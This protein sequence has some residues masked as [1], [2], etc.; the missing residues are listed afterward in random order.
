MCRAYEA[1]KQYITTRKPKDELKANSASVPVDFQMDEELVRDVYRQEAN[2]TVQQ[3]NLT[4]QQ[5]SV[6][7]DEV[8]FAPKLETFKWSQPTFEAV[9]SRWYKIATPQWSYA[10]TQD[11]QVIA[12]DVSKSLLNIASL[13]D[14]IKRFCYWRGGVKIR[15]QT[16]STPFHY[17]SLFAAIIPNYNLTESTSPTWSITNSVWSLSGQKCSGYLSANTGKPLEL[18]CPYQCPYEY[19]KITKATAE[20]PFFLM[21]CVMNPLKVA[22]GATNPTLQL[23]V[24]AQFCDFEVMGASESTANS[25]SKKIVKADLEQKNAVKQ[26]TLGKVAGA[27]SDI[28]GKLTSVPVIGSIASGVAPVASAIGSVLDF[29]GWDKPTNISS[30]VFNIS[31]NGRGLCHSSGLDPAEVLALKPENKVSTEMSNFGI[32]DPATRSLQAL[33]RTPMWTGSFTIANNQ[34]TENVFKRLWVKPFHPDVSDGG[35]SETQRHDYLSYYSHFFKACRGGYRY[36]FH[37]DT[38]S[39]TTARVRIT[40]E[41]S[42]NNVTAVTDGGDSFSRIVDI[43]GATTL[44]LDVPY[45]YPSAR[46]PVSKTLGASSS[47]GQLLFSLVNPI[48]T[49]G[50]SSDVIFVNVFRCAADDFRFYQLRKFVPVPVL[51]TAL[52]A[53]SLIE[54][55]AETKVTTLGDGP[56]VL[57]DRITED[58]E[59]IAHNDFLHRYHRCQPAASNLLT[60]IPS[61]GDSWYYLTPFRAYRGAVRAVAAAATTSNDGIILDSDLDAEALISAGSYTFLKD[62]DVPVEA[63]YNNNVRFLPINFSPT[64]Y[65]DAYDRKLWFSG[66]ATAPGLWAAGDDFTLGLRRSPAAITVPKA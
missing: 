42:A 66:E 32:D 56:K 3:D 64:I 17:G 19:L 23:S 9:V 38:S 49:N 37:F 40:F 16:N 39:Y 46:M 62:D 57:F 65:T 33:I 27:V 25:S 41:P 18:T 7:P 4:T 35:T 21:A 50:S 6:V 52:K 2:L 15:I 44:V 31:R 54:Q 61:A 20:Q 11:S 36:F 47:N 45:C 60:L 8:E 22:G 1:A 30:Q 63:P 53:N 55:L 13:F 34:A 24:F 51:A 58:E 14:R 43:N 59:V 29:F 10:S 48:Q 5:D 26:G 28:A 12:L